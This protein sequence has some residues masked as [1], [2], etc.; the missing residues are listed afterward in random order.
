MAAGVT[1]PEWRG[2]GLAGWLIASL[3]N[4]LAAEKD[5]CFLCL[6]HLRGFYQRLGFIQNDVIQQY[7]TDWNIK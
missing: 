2:R 6:P 7:T 1:A 3:A 4:E 5:A